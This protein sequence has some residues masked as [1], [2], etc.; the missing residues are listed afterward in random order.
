METDT[1][2]KRAKKLLEKELRW[3]HEILIVVAKLLAENKTP[4]RTLINILDVHFDCYI[5]EAVQIFRKIDIANADDIFDI[6]V[7]V[8]LTESHIAY[9]MTK[10][11]GIYPGYVGSLLAQRFHLDTRIATRIALS[12]VD[13][14]EGIRTIL[15]KEESS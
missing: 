6:L 7:K 3:R 10:L 5:V 12:P 4:L 13:P 2:I 15:E 11:L 9:I 1:I 8:Q 14:K